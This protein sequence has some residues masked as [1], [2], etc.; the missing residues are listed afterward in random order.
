MFF[1]QFAF[2]SFTINIKYD[3]HVLYD[4]VQVQVVVFF[5]KKIGA[6]ISIIK[7]CKTNSD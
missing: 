1:I 4:I 2:S 6:F 5:N 3:V 7:N